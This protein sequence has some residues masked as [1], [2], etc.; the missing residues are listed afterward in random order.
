M[1]LVFLAKGISITHGIPGVTPSQL[2][3][4]GGDFLRLEVDLVHPQSNA[5][6]QLWTETRFVEEHPFLLPSR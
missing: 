1:L 4:D 3:V 6:S 2:H 5:Y